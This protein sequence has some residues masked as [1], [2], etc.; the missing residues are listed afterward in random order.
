MTHRLYYSRRVMYPNRIRTRYC[1]RQILIGSLWVASDT[2]ATIFSLKQYRFMVR[3]TMHLCQACI[4]SLR[5][6]LFLARFMVFI[7]FFC[8]LDF[9]SIFYLIFLTLYILNYY[10]IVLSTTILY[11]GFLIFCISAYAYQIL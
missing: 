9:Y 6:G 4:F 3:P 7:P 11:S 5:I 8:K 2:N 1:S 10:L